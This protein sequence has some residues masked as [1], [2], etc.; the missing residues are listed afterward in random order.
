MFN[1]GN[2]NDCNNYSKLLPVFGI[3]PLDKVINFAPFIK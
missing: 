2:K 1:L 3:I